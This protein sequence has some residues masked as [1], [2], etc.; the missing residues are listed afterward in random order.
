VV[1][2]ATLKV[3]R[4]KLMAI[5]KLRAMSVFELGVYMDMGIE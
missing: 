3:A 1:R 2:P 5:I 4:L